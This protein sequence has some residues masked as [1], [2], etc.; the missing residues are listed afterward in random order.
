MQQYDNPKT[1]NSLSAYNKAEDASKI[2]KPNTTFLNFL[3]RIQKMMKTTPM[4]SKMI[5]SFSKINARI[6]NTMTKKPKSK[7]LAEIPSL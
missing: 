7:T 2:P 5:I 3:L 1:K 6:N 4:D